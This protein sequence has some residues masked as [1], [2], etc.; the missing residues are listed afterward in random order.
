MAGY[1]LGYQLLKS[2][3]VAAFL[4]IL[5]SCDNLRTLSDEW[6]LISSKNRNIPPPGPS[7]QQTACL[8]LDV[9]KDT[10]NDFIVASREAGPSVLWYRRNKLGWTKYLVD[11]TFL[12]IEAGGAFHDIDADGD[13]DILFGGDWQS[14]KVWWWE[15]PYPKYDPTTPWTRREI[16]NSG[17]NKHH[18]QIFGD[19]DGDGKMELVFWNQGT[20]KQGDNK[21]FI[22][23]IPIDSRN[24]Q[25]WPCAEIFS[26]SSEC[27]GLA[28]GDIDG[29]GKADIVGGGCWFKHNGGTSYTPN[30]YTPN[31]IDDEQR[32]ARVAVGQLSEGGRPEVVFVVGDGVGRL[33]WYE[34]KRSSWIGHDLLGFDV[35]HGHSLQVADINGDGKLD[36]F[37]GEMRLD[38][39]NKDAKMWIFLGDGRG[40]FIKKEIGSGY[41]VHEAKTGD[42]D[43]DGDIDILGKPYN[44]QTPRL[45]IWI[46]NMASKDKLTL[47]SWQRHIVDSKKPWQT[48]FITSTDMDNDGKKDIITGGWWYKNPGSPQGP[49]KRNLIGSPLYNMATVYDFDA[50]GDEDVLGTQG[51]GSIP[52]DSFV[53]AKNDG[54]GRFTIL[55]NVSKADGDFLQGVVVARFE[56]ASKLEVALSWHISGKG[57]QMLSVPLNPCVD[58]WLWRK[59]SAASQDEC[60]S[61][62]DIDLDG[63]VDL[64]LGTKWLRNDGSSWKVFSILK[65]SGAPDRNRLADINGDGRLDAVVGFEAISKKGKLVWYEQGSSPTSNWKEHVI[66]SI[67]GPMSLDVADM[68][69]DGDNDV[70]VGEHNMAN[71]SAASLYIFEN[72]DGRGGCW[73]PHAVFTGDEHHDGAHVVDIDTDGDLDIISIGWGHSNVILYENKAIAKAY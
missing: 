64:L 7:T 18:D 16:K 57:V 31:L 63:D 67:V 59:I 46:N 6:T 54:S 70:I 12:P 29:D 40:G 39:R 28:K 19:F 37:C 66:A 9:D 45:D 11:N 14:N 15:N 3:L 56:S 1:R 41:G 61:A 36:I 43:G 26:S 34:W 65:T 2:S 47:D 58:T 21:L 38:G 55:D 23:D 10:M 53:W 52:N 48:V 73:K 68:D 17:F 33:K 25:P 35:D 32:F 62:G 22:A 60:L 71:P 49:W 69:G 20:K 51:K 50:D 42:L 24:T 13:L 27:E 72:G 8:I 4:I 30:S 5:S 44:W